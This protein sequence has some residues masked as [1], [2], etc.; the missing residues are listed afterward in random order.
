MANKLSD[1]GP[2]ELKVLGI[3]NSEANQSVSDIQVLLK[4]N[5]HD[6]AYTTV[7]TVLV[8][9]FNKEFVVRQREGR[10]FLYS[11]AKKN[12]S[13][14]KIFERLKI[15]LFGNEKLRPI[16]GLLDSEEGLTQDEL[17]ELK[18]VVD[19]RLKRKKEPKNEL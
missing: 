6:L 11:P 7:L 16:L 10:L 9:L 15:S 18:K 13:P 8:R 1:V 3:L 4:Q 5:G 17:L 2:L 19:A 14:L 12:S